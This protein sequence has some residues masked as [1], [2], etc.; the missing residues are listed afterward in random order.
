LVP[1]SKK[2]FLDDADPFPDLAFIF[3]PIIVRKN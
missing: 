2:Y 3:F 1:S